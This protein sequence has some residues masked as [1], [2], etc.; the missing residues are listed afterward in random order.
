MKAFRSPEERGEGK[1]GEEENE[2][3]GRSHFHQLDL[4]STK[5]AHD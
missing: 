2:E 1:E 4:V 3:Q 5:P